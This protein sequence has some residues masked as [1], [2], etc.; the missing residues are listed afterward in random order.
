MKTMTFSG[1]SMREAMAQA[2]QRFGADVDILGSDAIDDGVQVTVVVPEARSSARRRKAAAQVSAG[3]KALAD[4]PMKGERAR[5]AAAQ[6]IETADQELA[7]A[8]TAPEPWDMAS[9]GLADGAA[10]GPAADPAAAGAGGSRSAKTA[11][12]TSSRRR[13]EP[14]NGRAAAG[15]RS[16]AAAADTAEV[17]AGAAAPKRSGMAAAAPLAGTATA[18]AAGPAAGTVLSTLD[19]EQQRRQRLLGGQ[20]ASGAAGAAQPAPALPAQ[21]TAL[22]QAMAQGASARPLAAAALPVSSL[23]A[24][25]TGQ[26]AAAAVVPAGAGQPTAGV[27]AAA[28][29]VP[30]AEAAAE[31]GM[32]RSR[33][34]VVLDS[35]RRMLGTGPG[36]WLGR[37][38]AADSGLPVAA[39]APAAAATG[40]AAAGGAFAAQPPASLSSLL[41]AEASDWP[42][43]NLAGD[44]ASAAHA[45]DGGQATEQ[46]RA[47]RREQE[48]RLDGIGW[49]E[50][51]RRRPGQM[52][53]LRNLL[54]C[55]FSPALARTLVSLLPVDYSDVQADE[56]LRQTMMRALTGVNSAAGLMPGNTGETVFDR[57]GV[58]ALIGPTGVGKTTSIAKIAA[59]HVLRHGPKSLALITADVY[60]IG[61]QEQLRAFGKMLGVPVQVAQDRDVLKTLLEEHATRSLV[62]IDTAGISQRDERVSRLTSALE[63]AQVK[64]VLVL[65]SGTQAGGIEDV[66]RAFGARETAGVLLS[67]VDEAVGLGACLD[68]LIRHRL[69]LVGYTDGQR[70]PEDYHAASLGQ[71][72]EA[73]LDGQAT[74]CCPSLSMTDSEIRHLF[75]GIH[76]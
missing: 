2:R 12:A 22:A 38:R 49:F 30:G 18:A 72:I 39:P 55:Q 66:L 32:N 24:A 11:R 58:F 15:G 57:G 33:L 54:A 40:A 31:A 53:L 75:E 63:L 37:N 46:A 59:H 44:D 5:K 50:L 7:A 28:G 69:P 3:I 34:S 1:R 56:W 6:P 74:N 19:F 27:A 29:A 26:P 61:A 13:A 14:K 64:R 20:A 41:Q 73:A 47:L 71:L 42:S 23:G 10:A 65:N 16:R 70:V 45:G 60:R 76:V 9:A 62:L 52:R 25:A 21:A 8:L 43:L 67:K 35:A 17:A 68:A 48:S 4:A 36:R 51:A